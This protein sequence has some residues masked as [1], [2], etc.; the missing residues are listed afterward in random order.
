MNDSIDSI[1][2]V[3]KEI[4]PELI[5]PNTDVIDDKEMRSQRVKALHHATSLGNLHQHKVHILFEDSEGI[6][7]VNTTIWAITE[8]KIILKNERAIP[9]AR[10]HSVIIG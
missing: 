2:L 5:F 3:M 7:R 8:K 4:I 6:K 10:I 1:P 9:I